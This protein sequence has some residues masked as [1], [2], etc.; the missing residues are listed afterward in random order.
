[1]NIPFLE[2][3]GSSYKIGVAIGS[4]FRERMQAFVAFKRAQS[5]DWGGAAATE[6]AG[7]LQDWCGRMAP[8]LLDEMRGYADGADVSFEDVIRIN[9]GDEA[10]ARATSAGSDGCTGFALAP[11]FTGHG[12]LAGQSKDGPGPQDEHYVVVLMRPADRPAVLQLTYPGMLAVFGLSGTGMFLGANQIYDGTTFTGMPVMLAKRLTWET[13]SVD[14]AAS[15]FSAH[16]LSAA[17]NYLLC[18]GQGRAACLEVNGANCVRIDPEDGMIVH[19]NHYLCEALR[20]GENETSIEAYRSRQRRARLIELLRSQ[21]GT[22][23]P[24]SIFDCYRDHDGYP[25][26]ICTH[27]LPAEH[28]GTTAVLV[29]ETRTRRL[30]VCLGNPCRGRPKAFAMDL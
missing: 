3:S 23:T 25:R 8:H 6:G 21:R 7:I 1:M 4:A 17:N 19:T 24:S 29:A 12:A 22:A 2:V 5:A 26:S 15:L 18:D 20:G 30:H 9:S 14:E 10:R 27:R 13:S 11:Q 16:G 28:Y